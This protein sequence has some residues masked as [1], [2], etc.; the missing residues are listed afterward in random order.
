MGQVRFNI[1]MEHYS[2]KWVKLSSVDMEDDCFEMG[3]VDSVGRVCHAGEF[4]TIISGYLS[5]RTSTVQHR[6]MCQAIW[7]I[8]SVKC[9]S[10]VFFAPVQLYF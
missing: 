2:L 3:Q 10:T 9:V 1:D 4:V 5:M 7:F 6:I 8:Q